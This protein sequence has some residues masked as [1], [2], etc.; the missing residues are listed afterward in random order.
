MNV[1]QLATQKPLAEGSRR[2]VF[3]H[4]EDPGLL[5]KVLKPGSYSPDGQPKRRR[6]YKLRRREGAFIYHTRELSEYVATRVYNKSPQRLPICSIQGLVETDLGL[7]LAVEKVTGCDGGLAP[8]L[9][10]V[11]E[12]GQFDS[13]TRQLFESFIRDMID[14]HVVVYELSIDNIVLADDGTQ[15]CRFVCVDGMGSRTLIPIQEWSKW[16]NA[17]KIREFHAEIQRHW[18]K[19][20]V[21]P[22]RR[23]A[24]LPAPTLLVLIAVESLI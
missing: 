14:K 8:T 20:A 13:R 11:I 21:S 24:F 3:Q 2:L 1:L 4:P 23:V 16:I 17:R 9:R 12:R 7:G 5:I 10:Q 6:A 15:E 18:K 19:A 22:V